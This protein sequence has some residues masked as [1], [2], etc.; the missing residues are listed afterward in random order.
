MEYQFAYRVDNMKFLSPSL[1][2]S[3]GL[4][5]DRLINASLVKPAPVFLSESPIPWAYASWVYD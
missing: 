2:R 5:L 4:L 1:T 3:P